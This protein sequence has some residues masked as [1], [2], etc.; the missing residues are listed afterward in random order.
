MFAFLCSAS[1]L[2]AHIS[3]ERSSYT[4]EPSIEERIAALRS[5]ELERIRST[6]RLMAVNRFMFFSIP[7]I[8][9]VVTFLTY[10]MLGNEMDAS[11]VFS[12]M[13]LLNLIQECGP[14][15]QRCFDYEVMTLRTSALMC[16][17]T[18]MAQCS[19]LQ[20]LA[21]AASCCCNCHTSSCGTGTNKSIPRLD[22]TRS[23]AG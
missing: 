4:W 2:F 22:R 6:E 14:R 1:D 19:M 8:T 15:I 5:V 7:V 21:A 12:S 13:A 16:S 11:L 20:V 9:A 17:A 10:T 18:C 3:M 23:A